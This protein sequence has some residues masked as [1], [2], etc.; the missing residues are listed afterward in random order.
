[1]REISGKKDGGKITEW[2]KKPLTIDD[3]MVSFPGNVFDKHRIECFNRNTV[4]G[5]LTPSNMF[6]E[7][8]PL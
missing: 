7:T 4:L 8:S 5:N 1:M 2:I 3:E 6:L